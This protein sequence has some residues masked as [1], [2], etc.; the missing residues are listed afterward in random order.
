M[1]LENVLNVISGGT[2][3]R[4]YVGCIKIFEGKM[5]EVKKTWWD[6]NVKQFYGCEVIRLNT[7]DNVI[8]IAV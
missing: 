3:I 7:V 4:I 2:K 5:C 8:T 1:K 6:E